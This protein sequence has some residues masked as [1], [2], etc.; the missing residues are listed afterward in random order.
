MDRNE[1]IIA[2]SQIAQSLIDQL[3]NQ[4]PHDET[5]EQGGI[6]CGQEIVEG[7]IHHN[8]QNFAIEHLLYIIYESKI[9]FPTG[10]LELLHQIVKECGVT[11]RYY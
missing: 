8:E 7:Y 5:F 4:N 9:S 1:E 11:T 6:I 3:Y 2:L 10:K